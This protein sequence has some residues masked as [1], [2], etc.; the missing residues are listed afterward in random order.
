[1]RT[2]GL[3]LALFL[4]SCH[5]PP[6]GPF[7]RLG[8][9]VPVEA[10]PL[11]LRVYVSRTANLFHM[12]DELS[13][14]SRFCHR[15]YEGWFKPD[16]DDRAWLGRHA[17]V[18]RD[19]GWGGGFERTFYTTHELDAALEAGVARGY[20]TRRQADLEREVL[21]RFAARADRLLEGQRPALAALEE[22]L[23]ASRADIESVAGRLAAFTGTPRAFVP[24]FPIAS[25]P[26]RRGGGSFDGGALTVEVADVD[27][28]YSVFLHEVFHAFLEPRKPMIRKAALGVAGLDG[29]TLV[30]ALAYALSPGLFSGDASDTLSE[31]VAGDRRAGRSLDEPYTRYCRLALAI[32][33]ELREAMAEGVTLEEFLPRAIDA[34][35]R[36]REAA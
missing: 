29:Q 6:L 36:I 24:V 14:W 16:A 12:V 28:A 5:T 35:A 15:Q 8:G 30:E 13:G 31:I 27:D 26:G 33:E 10:G 2:E 4:S 25:P 32:R 1:M 3:F 20:L 19:R 23:R 17:A 34:W 22:R 21:G 18:R 9:G 11:E 7:P